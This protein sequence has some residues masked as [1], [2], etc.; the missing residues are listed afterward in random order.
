LPGT[1]DTIFDEVDT[2]LRREERP[3]KDILNPGV[4]AKLLDQIE[5]ADI[6]PSILKAFMRTPAVESMAGADSSPEEDAGRVL[7]PRIL[8]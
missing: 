1:Y 6:D 5:S 8:C 7:S 2:L 3:L 4:L